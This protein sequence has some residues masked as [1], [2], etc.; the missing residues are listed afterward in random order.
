MPKLTSL[1]PHNLK[2]KLARA[3]LEPGARAG[4]GSLS[5]MTN[6]EHPGPN[7]ICPQSQEDEVFPP[8]LLGEIAQFFLDAAPRPVRQIAIS[9]ATAYLAGIAGNAFNVSGTG[10][11]QYILQLAGTGTGKESVANAKGR[12][13]FHVH[14]QASGRPFPHNGPGELVSAAGLIKWQVDYPCNLTIIGEATKKLKEITNPRNPNAYGL[15]RT[16]LQLFSKSGAQDSF[17]PMAYS[18]KEKR[19]DVIYSPS[20]TIWGEGNPEDFYESLD[21]TL[22]SDGLLPRFMVFEYR[23]KRER[24]N[25]LA[26]DAAPPPALVQR[27]KDLVAQC[28]T[29][30]SNRT[31]HNVQLTP[32]AEAIFDAYDVQTTDIINGSQA[33]AFRQLYNRAH[34]KALKLAALQAVGENPIAP[35]IGTPG[36][37]WAINLIDRQTQSLVA[38]FAS[39]EVGEVAGNQT[40][41][42]R[43][44]RKVIRDYLNAEA[45]KYEKSGCTIKMHIDFIFTKKYLS[46]RLINLA[47]YRGDKAGGT[48]ALKR[49]IDF[50]QEADEIRHVNPMDMQKLFGTSASAFGV[51]KAAEFLRRTD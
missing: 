9:G 44:I 27:L 14:D 28:G 22:I 49:N 34:L 43:L 15:G 11:N 41:Q 35:V 1:K 16:I 6:N 23:G 19:T 37:M 18:D 7:A 51:T 2:T 31:A 32:E 33:E 5:K 45:G 24:L 26:K 21:T 30:R 4:Q 3:G 39:G 8:G 50:L 47:A 29:I 42:Q 38:R 40:A 12:L 48:A 25:K 13:N 36:A 10:L 17:D 20:L 46:D